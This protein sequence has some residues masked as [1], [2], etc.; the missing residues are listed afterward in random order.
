[1]KAADNTTTLESR[2]RELEAQREGTYDKRTEHLDAE[3]RAIYINRLIEED[4]PY[5]LH[6]AHNPVNWF[7]WGN[8]AFTTAKAE[9][10][11]IFLSIGYSTCHWC[12]VMEIESFDLSL[13]HI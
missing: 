7:P 3:G 8:E 10:K 9:D 6:H 4:S 5:L 2:L 1:M 11:P 13:I 12:H